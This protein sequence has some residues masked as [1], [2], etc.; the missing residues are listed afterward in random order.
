MLRW[1]APALFGFV[2]TFPSVGYFVLFA[3]RIGP[4]IAK[5]YLDFGGSPPFI[6]RI[7]VHPLT[8]FI[9]IATLLLGLI[10]GALRPN[11]RALIMPLTAATGLLLSVGS[12]FA[13][14]VPVFML[15]DQIK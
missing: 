9:I 14:Y 3:T 12:V 5:M 10:I 11:E 8:P 2:L 7:A 1:P 4:A 13:V 15:A 6:A